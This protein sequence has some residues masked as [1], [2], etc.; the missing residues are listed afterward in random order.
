ME[1]L[2]KK[3]ALTISWYVPF[4]LLLPVLL[5]IHRSPSSI[6]I[7][8]RHFDQNGEVQETSILDNENNIKLVHDVTESSNGDQLTTSTASEKFLENLREQCKKHKSISFICNSLRLVLPVTSVQSAPLPA[9]SEGIAQ[10]TDANRQSLLENI[11]L[12]KR[13][14]Q[15]SGLSDTETYIAKPEQYDETTVLPMVNRYNFH[16]RHKQGSVVT[17]P[18]GEYDTLPRQPYTYSGPTHLLSDTDDDNYNKPDVFHDMVYLNHDNYEDRVLSKTDKSEENPYSE[19]IEANVEEQYKSKTPGIFSNMV[20]Q[21]HNMTN[22][23]EGNIFRKTD[24]TDQS[25]YSESMETNT[26]INTD[27]DEVE[28]HEKNRSFEME[29]DDRKK[30]AVEDMDKLDCDDKNNCSV[31]D[32][33]AENISEIAEK[34]DGG[35]SDDMVDRLIDDSVKTLKNSFTIKFP[36]FERVTNK[37]TEWLKSVFGI[38]SRDEGKILC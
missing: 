37:I 4:S 38:K 7:D 23:S 29:E 10:T 9:A 14:T 27:Y 28:E 2:S 17:N 15:S 35:K 12:Q 21:N 31:G 36:T 6:L 22:I 1:F 19:S 30:Y 16:H 11:K 5:A 25:A 26:H 18:D 24:R 33:S 8:N 34:G 3:C 32:N 20:Y 13:F